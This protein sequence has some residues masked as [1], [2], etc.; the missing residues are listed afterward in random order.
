MDLLKQAINQPPD[1]T[2][3]RR[4]R[5]AIIRNTAPQLRDTTIKTVHD[6]IP[7][8]IAGKWMKSE[9]AFN[10][11]FGDVESEWLFRALDDADDIANL[12]SLEITSCW[13]N[14]YRTIDPMVFAGV[15]GR[16]GRFPKKKFVPPWYGVVMDSNPPDE[17]DFFYK[18]FEEEMPPEMKQYEEVMARV[19]RPLLELY[20][21]PSG[22]SEDAENAEHLPEN[23]Y[24]TILIG[25][26]NEDYIRKHVHG[27][28]GRSQE[29]QPVYPDFRYDFHVSRTP[30]LVNPNE[31]LAIGLDFG[32]TPAACFAQQHHGRW[33]ILKELTTKEPI[34]I[35]RFIESKL[36]PFLGM[37]FPDCKEFMMWADPAGNQRSQ[38][39]ERTCF[40][41]LRKFGFVPRGGPQDLTTRVGS[42]TRVLTRQVDGMPG[43]IIDPSCRTIIN[44]LRGRYRY[45]Q[46]KTDAKDWNPTPEKNHESHV[47]DALEYVIGA[48]EAP[49]LRSA[50][51][52]PRPWGAN[53]QWNKPIQPKINAAWG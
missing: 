30:L 50:N 37:Y 34:G 35:E 53:N 51:A 33:M 2:G 45:K 5:F 6:W 32:L 29:G 19:G 17:G 43:C 46:K 38:V 40:Q 27:E 41:V 48:Y 18:L 22:L 26:H 24:Q 4:T 16:V 47:M 31:P 52:R 1:D 49:A 14:E 42:L 13:I 28:Y 36:N 8:G 15:L 25:G 21:Q 10:L 7:P 12:M 11:Q 39:D 20:R 23:Y 3:K 9:K 44:G